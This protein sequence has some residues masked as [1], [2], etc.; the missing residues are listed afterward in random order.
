MKKK[1]FL[2]LFALSALFLPG[3][4]IRAQDPICMNI[5]NEGLALMNKKNRNSYQE[6][7]KKF[8][9]AGICDAKLLDD[10][11]KRISE[12]KKAIDS[13]P[14]A[15]PATTPASTPAP[16][17]KPTS[18]P[19]SKPAPASVRLSR[20]NL[21]FS[22]QGGIEN[23]TVSGDDGWTVSETAD[24]CD[25]KRGGNLVVITCNPNKSSLSRN[26][27]VEIKGGNSS[28]TVSIE[29]EAAAEYLTVSKKT[30]EYASPGGTD[31]VRI[32]TNGENWT[33][34]DFPAWCN[35]RKAGTDGL[36][37]VCLENQTNQ[38]RNEIIQLKTGRQT[39]GV[40]IKQDARKPLQAN[41]VPETAPEASERK[42][43]AAS[44]RDAT[45]ERRGT[46]GRRVVSGR[47]SA[48]ARDDV[49]GRESP[50][51]GRK[52]SFGIMAN[53]LIPDFSVKS[54]S[55]L[56]SAVNYGYGGKSETPSYSLAEPG[57][58]GGVV[59]DIR[60]SE[61]IYLQTGLYYTN[62][63]MNNKIKGERNDIIRDYTSSTYLEGTVF[64]N[65]TEKYTLNYIELPVLLSYRHRLSEKL[66]WQVSA[67]PYVGYGITGKAKIQGTLDWPALL[68][69]YNSDDRPTGGIYSR[70]NALAGELDLFGKTGS[71]SRT[72]DQP[73][74][75]R[76]DFKNAPF[77]N[78]NAGVSIGTA[79][80]YAGFNVGVYYDM[81]LMNIANGDYWNSERMP[82]G[83]NA[84]NV[85]IDNYVHRLNKI[86]IRVG[87]IYRW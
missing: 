22:E 69:Y 31:S 64:Y 46:A 39:I 80:E 2:L 13:P 30:L 5:Y 8:E 87:Y 35:V 84:D 51:A 57:F 56:G 17:S 4:N 59:A 42:R 83:D 63:S 66:I 11:K 25:A 49:S 23:I 50:A 16:T 55:V 62:I 19:A 72:G 71:L 27:T 85:A 67:G 58:S 82:A 61:N 34:G 32:S 79:I 81:G 3:G 15:T 70:S 75:N 14:A 26:T 47:E 37:I 73:G 6:A 52:I 9:A 7:V 77:R 65:I 41:A 48:P 76:S 86:Q 40:E 60:I 36:I 10:C 21:R 54:S 12:C 18:K 44:G 78:L 28:R 1:Y 45:S 24:W 53:V 33:I 20:E 29:Q 43:D 74:G 38:A 68:E